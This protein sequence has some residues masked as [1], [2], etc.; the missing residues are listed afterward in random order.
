[1][2]FVIRGRVEH[3]QHAERRHGD[4]LIH[5]AAAEEVRLLEKVVSLRE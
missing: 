4:L 2:L 1:M 3:L 5:I